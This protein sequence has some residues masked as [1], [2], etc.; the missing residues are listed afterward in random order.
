[1]PAFRREDARQSPKAAARRAP[2]TGNE[3]CTPQL[4]S[5]KLCPPLHHAVLSAFV[6]A[7][8]PEVENFA[9]YS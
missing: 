2:A 1:M 5:N 7:P 9:R 6:V 3:L 4:T 8:M